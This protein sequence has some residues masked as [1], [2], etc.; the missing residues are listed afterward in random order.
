MT[1]LIRNRT[2][3]QQIKDFSGLQWGKITPTDID[4]M[5]EFNGKLFVLIECKYG[6]SE[7]GVGQRL[8]LMRAAAAI[9]NP[10]ERYASIIWAS[11]QHSV[12][13]DISFSELNAVQCWWPGE[14]ITKVSGYFKKDLSDLDEYWVNAGISIKELIDSLRFHVGISS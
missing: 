12:E 1:S 6:T 2:Q 14:K 11:S 8:A 4:A 9:H 10:P 5:V 7:I 13:E 3:I